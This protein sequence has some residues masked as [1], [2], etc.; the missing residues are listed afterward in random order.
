MPSFVLEP[1]LSAAFGFIVAGLIGIFLALSGRLEIC[2][3]DLS[4]GL[5][6]SN[7]SASSQIAL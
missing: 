5:S 2:L 3:L 7:Y 6:T 1:L 4:F